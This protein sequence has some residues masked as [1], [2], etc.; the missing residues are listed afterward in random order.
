MAELDARLLDRTYDFDLPPQHQHVKRRQSM[1]KTRTSS[2]LYSRPHLNS[3]PS[4]VPRYDEV[5]LVPREAYDAYLSERGEGSHYLCRPVS[6]N[7]PSGR[8]L[9]PDMT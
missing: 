8:S 4:L 2:A 1:R 6:R 3:V 5:H 9:N 7:C